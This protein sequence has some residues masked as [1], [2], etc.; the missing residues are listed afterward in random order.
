M[1]V[2][3]KKGLLSNTFKNGRV[4]HLLPSINKKHEIKE[5]EREI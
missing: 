1:S 3:K 5:K 4:N 2:N